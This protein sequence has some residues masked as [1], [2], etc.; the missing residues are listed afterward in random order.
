MGNETPR[1]GS[2]L[3]GGGK[4]D[5]H[6]TMTAW[7][8]GDGSDRNRAAPYNSSQDRQEWASS[9]ER[10][11]PWFGPGRR[12]TP[13]DFVTDKQVWFITG[14]GR[15]MGADFAWAVLAAGHALVAT[16]RNAER[17]TRVLGRS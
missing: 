2:A 5:T 3:A 13:G 15:G 6:T 16:G 8:L 7:P 17:L 9:S 14:A 4:Y 10:M 12:H 11:P 1:S